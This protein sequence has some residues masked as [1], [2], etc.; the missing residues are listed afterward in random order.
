MSVK[1]KIFLL[2]L[3]AGFTMQ[4][5][6]VHALDLGTSATV[7]VKEFFSLALDSSSIDFGTLNQGQW[8]EVS[9]SS[10]YANAA[11][12]YSN[13]GRPWTL[14]IRA[15]SPLTKGSST[16]SVD[17]LKWMST[18][19]GSKNAPYTNYSD[20]LLN[21]PSNGYIDFSLTDKAVFSSA[22]ASIPNNNTLPN[23]VEV[24][25]KYAILI[26]TNIKVDPGTY[27]TTITYTLTE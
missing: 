27:T 22:L 11:I 23:G 24:Q 17:V 21:P 26:P 20:G 10:G 7:T 9:G 25:F 4:S 14:S 15:S 2:V 8:K 13:T 6:S 16:I 1:G 18:Y 19:A 3:L 12:C 5:I